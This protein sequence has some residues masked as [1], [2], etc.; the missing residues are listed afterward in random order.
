MFNAAYN[1][2]DNFERDLFCMLTESY[3]LK[4]FLLCSPY[5]SDP[6]LNY[7]GILS[8]KHE[9]AF[10]K[11][12]YVEGRKNIEE[13]IIHDICSGGKSTIKIVG[14]KGCGKTTLIHNLSRILSEKGQRSLVLDFGDQHATLKYDF[15]TDSVVQTIY[16]RFVDDRDENNCN[17]LR[18]MATL[19]SN[20]ESFI[21]RKWDANHKIDSVFESIANLVDNCCAEGKSILQK[22]RDE[23]Y[24]ME[25]YQLIFIFLLSD[26]YENKENKRTTIFLDNLD[27]MIDHG[28]IRKILRQYDNFLNGMGSLYDRIRTFLD[29]EYAYRYVFVFVLRDSTVS[30]L[31][32]HEYA[33]R[34]ITDEEY[35]V[36][37]HYSKKE[38]VSKRLE[39][40]TKFTNTYNNVNAARK[41][42]Y[43]KTIE[44]LRNILSDSYVTETIFNIFNNDYRICIMTMIKI[45]SSGQ[46]SNR[47]YDNIKRA[48]ALH[49]SRGIIYRLLFNNFYKKGYFKR[50]RITDFKNRGIEPSS[51]SRLLLTYIANS[52]DVELSHD[53]RKVSFD[54]LL[55]EIDGQIEKNDVVRCLWGMYNLVTADD[56]CNL[57]SFAESNDASE[58]GLVKEYDH[59]TKR[60]NGQTF[61]NIEYSTFRITTAG[62]AFLTYAC[63]HFEFFACR[64]LS[65]NYPPL[66][67]P[68]S[69]EE[70]EDG[71]VF[72]TIINSVLEEVKTCAEK[73]AE[74][75]ESE[76]GLCSFA[77]S[78]FV[79]KKQEKSA[80]YHVERMVF[81]H[82]RYLDEFR[83][84]ALKTK[85]EGLSKEV[86]DYALEKIEEYLNILNNNEAKCSKQGKEVILKTLFEL[87]EDAKLDPY[88]PEKIIG[89]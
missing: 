20:I 15:A 30:Y 64:S 28:D 41:V 54:D 10:V 66:F 36:T 42:S 52:T 21:D 75:Y 83:R 45:A 9:E 85:E 26:I 35:D 31:T 43:D 16:E 60:K 22:I 53:S 1:F 88:N 68:K 56:W 87:L 2:K 6:I 49:G 33:I 39:L 80:Q 12:L 73:L 76:S 17:A 19:Y 81:S 13:N 67:L 82:V 11:H 57:I 59:Y 55:D 71:Y 5:S 48:G 84:F 32:G 24:D 62:L 23:L 61:K 29:N 44:L 14:N 4:R 65:A 40:F 89:K 86:S 34:Q 70:N 27:N 63:I 58:Q 3:D 37:R 38:I 50:I 74:T 72:K 78:T 25:L 51:P 46:V 77:N 18:W 8:K 47:D 79:F 69:F 7:G